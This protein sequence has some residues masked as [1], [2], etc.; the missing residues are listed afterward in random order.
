[1]CN[2]SV[3]QT[4]QH[5]AFPRMT[6]Q[7]SRKCFSESLNSLAVMRCGVRMGLMTFNI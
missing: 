6:Q 1:M 3:P 4:A 5:S 7:A 2:I